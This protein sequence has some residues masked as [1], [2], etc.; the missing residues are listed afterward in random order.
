LFCFCIVLESSKA[1]EP[2]KLTSKRFTYS[3]KAPK[4]FLFCPA[5]RF[6]QT[7][8][9]CCKT[10]RQIPRCTS[11]FIH[12]ALLSLARARFAKNLCESKQSAWK[13]A[14]EV[15]W[16]CCSRTQRI[17]SSL[18]ILGGCDVQKMCVRVSRVIG[19]ELA[20]FLN[21]AALEHSV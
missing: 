13:R 12:L 17:K 2:R 15:P 20:N 18:A 11:A 16:L 4:Y 1:K 7:C 21:S 14:C 3:R 10:L 9:T 8:G 6:G 5:L 19:S